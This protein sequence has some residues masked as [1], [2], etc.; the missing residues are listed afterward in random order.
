M[1][2][3]AWPVVRRY[4]LDSI[5]Q[6]ALGAAIGTAVMGRT[7]PVWQAALIGA[8]IGTLPDLDVFI[9]K[10]DPIRDMVLH[11]AETHALFWQ[12]L[13]SPLIAGILALVTRS[14]KRFLH[15]WLMVVLVLFTHSTL[16]GMT[17]Y[18]TQLGL[19]F[20]NYPYG[21]GSIFII[22]P[23]Y[24]LPL[25][26]GLILTL[27]IRSNRRHH[28]NIAGLVLSTLYA[29]WSVAAQ[30]HVTE[31]VKETAEARH[32]P[33]ESILVTPTPFNTVLWRI[34][35]V[36]DTHYYEGFYSLLDRMHDPDRPIRFDAFDRGAEFDRKT[37][38]F[39]EANKIRAFSKGFYT[40]SDDGKEL[41]ITDLRMGQHPYF[42]FSFVFAEHSSEP[43]LP[44]TPRQI[45]MRMPFESGIDWLWQRIGGVDTAPPR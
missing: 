15:W 7:R 12:A 33:A 4:G 10:G 36:D 29:G 6:A 38:D 21:L 32:L 3:M 35:L 1:P 31:L 30:H 18:G 11:R 19:P 5:T 14:R 28:W 45:T 26:F 16:D 22:D 27:T 24:T 41:R 13:V 44:I 43:I 17:I 34:I 37:S 25:L 20:T 23:L 9:D 42:V 39:S 8:L 2:S 40:I